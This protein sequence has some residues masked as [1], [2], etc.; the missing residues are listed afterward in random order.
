MS[1]KTLYAQENER[2]FPENKSTSIS[3][4]QPFEIRD[5]SAFVLHSSKKAMKDDDKADFFSHIFS[6]SLKGSFRFL[7]FQLGCTYVVVFRTSLQTSYQFL[8]PLSLDLDCLSKRGLCAAKFV[9]SP[10]SVHPV[11]ERVFESLAIL[12]SIS[13]NSL[14]W[15]EDD[16]QRARRRTC[17]WRTAGK[18]L[19]TTRVYC[20]RVWRQTLDRKYRGS[21][22]LM[23]NDLNGYF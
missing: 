16:P 1:G 4:C 6:C 14:K 11:F 21:S 18:E 3:H 12:S 17:Q 20:G 5:K 19:R 15:L 9:E 10:L 7:G 22:T 23:W 8:Q 2:F 13:K